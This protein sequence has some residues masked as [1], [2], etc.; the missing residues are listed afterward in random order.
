MA[1]MNPF[2]IV[3]PTGF[4]D[5]LGSGVATPSG[6]TKRWLKDSPVSMLKEIDRIQL[7]KMRPGDGGHR[8]QFFGE[9]KRQLGHSHPE[10]ADCA[11]R[12][13]RSQEQIKFA[14]DGMVFRF[15]AECKAGM[16]PKQPAYNTL[17]AGM[18]LDGRA[19]NHGIYVGDCAIDGSAIANKTWEAKID[20]RFDES[21]L[22]RLNPEPIRSKDEPQTAHDAW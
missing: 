8:E 11:Y 6:V 21:I 12:E 14:T 13:W 22:K 16:C 4:I 15:D 5:S 7:H 20:A 1:V 2:D 9:F 19:V 18:N 17:L 10:C 3:L